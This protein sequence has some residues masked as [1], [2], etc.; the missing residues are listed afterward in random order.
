MTVLSKRHIFWQKCLMAG[1]SLVIIIAVFVS[2]LQHFVL[3]LPHLPKN[4]PMVDGIVVTTGGQDRL[5]AGLDLLSQNKAPY[6]LL[7]GVGEGITKQMIKSSLALTPDRAAQLECCVALEFQAKDTKGNALA[8]KKWADDN[9]L[10]VILLVTAD[11][12]MPRARLEFAA[13]MPRRTIVAYPINAADLDGKS[14]YSDW[15]VM[16]L[17][18]RE[19][20][21]YSLRRLTLLI[22]PS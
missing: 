1:S 20:L 15:H 19:F 14:W 9:Q 22:Q 12:H 6:L 5:A 21:K 13:Q 16:R 7:S 8:T 11:Y 3:T 18:I 10:S 4:T 17:Y 2:I